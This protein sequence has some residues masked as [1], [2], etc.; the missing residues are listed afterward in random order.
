[1]VYDYQVEAGFDPK[2]TAFAQSLGIF[3]HTAFEVVLPGADRFREILEGNFIFQYPS[4]V[5]F[6]I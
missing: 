3:G 4:I 6:L 1:M 5:Y 2:T